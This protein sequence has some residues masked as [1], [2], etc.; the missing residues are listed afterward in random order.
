[1]LKV[2]PISRDQ[3][4]CLPLKLLSVRRHLIPGPGWLNLIITVSVHHLSSHA[5][6]FTLILFQCIVTLRE[7]HCLSIN[8][9]G[10]LDCSRLLITVD[11]ATVY[12]YFSELSFC[13]PWHTPGREWGRHIDTAKPFFKM[14][15]WSP[16][17]TAVGEIAVLRCTLVRKHVKCYAFGGMY[18]RIPLHFYFPFM[19]VPHSCLDYVLLSIFFLNSHNRP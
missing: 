6:G 9:Y 1:M 17:S 13:F 19:A 3:R 11:T 7:V 10:Y 4:D 15:P 5:A 2:V 8:A 14:A 18:R 12:T 16:G